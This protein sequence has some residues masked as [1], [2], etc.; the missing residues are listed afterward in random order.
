MSDR[1]V[2]VTV[3]YVLG[4]GVA[5]LLISGLL[6]ATGGILEDRQESTVRSELEVVGEQVVTSLSAADRLAQLQGADSVVVTATAP[7]RVAGKAYT[8]TVNGTSQE[9][10][11]E[12]HDGSVSV[13][14][15]FHNTTDVSTSRAGGGDI[16]VVLTDAGELEVRSA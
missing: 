4:L 2:S 15:P 14:V 16:E 11:L 5:T 6:M 13:E 8:I 1:G 10:V 3:N 7:Q 12:N 9:V